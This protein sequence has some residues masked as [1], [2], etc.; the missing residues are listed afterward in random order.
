MKNLSKIKEK[1]VK[2]YGLD[3]VNVDGNE[4]VLEVVPTGSLMLDYKTGIGGFPYGFAVEVYGGNRMG[5]SSSIGY[6]VLGN[7]QRQGRVACVIASE[8]RL[9]TKQDV[10]WARSMGFDPEEALI[11]YPDH[12][13]EAF[14]MLRDAV[15]ESDPNLRPDY[16]MIDSLGG[17]GTMATAKQDG[18]TTK[19][20]GIS[21]PV[22]T[23]LN[24]IMPRLMKNH[25][26]LLILNQQRQSGSTMQ[27]YTL[28]ESPGGEGLHHQMRMRI[29]L[30]QAGRLTGTYQHESLQVGRTISCKFVKHN[31]DQREGATATFDFYFLGNDD[32][33]VGIDAAK[34]VV[35]TGVLAGVI[36]KSGAWFEH[37]CFPNSKIQGEARAG[38][39]VAEHEDTYQIIRSQ[40]LS[41]MTVETLEMEAKV[42]KQNG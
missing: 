26:G 16:I 31:M 19:A 25:Q 32:H 27:G 17:M 29:Q 11:L 38:A 40:V 5:K 24:D 2:G 18:K 3:Y 42:R 1:Y 13:E 34:D 12:A 30:K 22:T 36:K 4:Y 33:G 23:V 41:A 10:E 7:V 37:D 14:D 8:P 39:F 35:T 6:P 15:F 9:I 28:Y 20:Y 21:G